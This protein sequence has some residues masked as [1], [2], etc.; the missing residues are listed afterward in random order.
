MNGSQAG[1]IE[2]GR[3]TLPKAERLAKRSDIKRL[4][5]HGEAFLVYPVKCTYLFRPSGEGI[6][7]RNRIMV[8]VSKRNHRRA[9]ARN[10]LKRR[11][12]EAYRLN[13]RSAGEGSSGVGLDIAFSYIAKGEPL[14]YRTIEKAVVSILNKLCTIRNQRN[15]SEVSGVE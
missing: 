10:Q 11:M 6:G 9:V 13:K 14:D 15:L 7:A 5:A 8:I 12:R 1:S 3:Y 2:T 4:F